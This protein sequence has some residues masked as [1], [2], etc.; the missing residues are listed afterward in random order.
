[1]SLSIIATQKARGVTATGSSESTGEKRK[2]DT[3]GSPAQGQEP[4]GAW[5]DDARVLGKALHD[6]LAAGRSVIPCRADTKKCAL[7]EWTTWQSQIAPWE[8]AKKW[9]GGAI[10]IVGGRVSG[11]LECVDFDDCGSRYAAWSEMVEAEAP[12]LLAKLTIEQ[13][14][15][16]GFHVVYRCTE[17]SIPGSLNLASRG[18]ETE[19]HGYVHVHGKRLKGKRYGA[20]WWAVQ[21]LIETR[22]EG[23]YFVCAPSA[24]YVL[25]QGT[26]KA[27][28]VIT[29]SE[30]KLL[31]GIARRFNEW[32]APE[33]SKDG[34]S[35][36]PNATDRP[37]DDFNSRPDPEP[38]DM[39]IEAD[40]T[41]CGLRGENMEDF[42][43]PGKEEGTSGTLIGGRV[44][45]VHTTNGEPLEGE[46]SYSPFA[47]FTT[48]K[49]GGDF[50]KATKF[51]AENGF[52]KKRG[53]GQADSLSQD[54]HA[55]Q[56]A[57]RYA[58]SFRYDHHVGA[59]FH[60][61]GSRW[62]KQETKLAFQLVREL[63]RELAWGDQDKLTAAHISGV[64][65]LAQADPILACTSEAWDVDPFLLG[66]PGGVVD[67][68][69]GTVMESDPAFMLTKQT[70]VSPADDLDC[71]RWLQFLDEATCGDRQ[72]QRF[73]QQV[74]G[75]ALTG[76]TREHALFF[77]YGP[78]GNGKSVFLNAIT[79]VMGDYATTSSMDTFTESR[80][81]R[82][83]TDLAML[84]GA[85]LVTASE[86]EEGR[87]WAE[88]RIKQLTGGE[89]ISARFMRQDFF[90]FTPQFKL[91]IIGNHQPV[92]NNV[93]DAARRRFNII[94]FV[95]KPANVD[96][97]LEQKLKAEYPG[98]LRWMIQGCVDWL[99]SG[100]VRPDIVSSATQEYFDDQ[101]VFGQWIAEE[102]ERSPSYKEATATLFSAWSR[103][104]ERNGEKPGAIKT[105]SGGLTRR[106]FISG[107]TKSGRHFSGLRL[108]PDQ[109]PF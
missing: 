55:Q 20:K 5:R 87:A 34:R 58:E 102:C 2:N 66:T 15:S 65:K 50:K 17:A 60:W 64:E 75:Y 88:A 68:R 63:C 9:P 109:E 47:L 24:G 23:N 26:H 39:L 83:P 97:Q 29:A 13:S 25:V 12:G 36:N 11:N 27:P 43:R 48:L 72:L 32:A 56:F 54:G 28:P 53:K 90:E 108:K 93:D 3:S 44:F 78:G 22:G 81:E 106:G 95:H 21:K 94:P 80:S 31:L 59:W 6:L 8:T 84:R 67:L 35:W 85:R 69:T 38:R 92:L 45:Y 49:H 52:G 105:F 74:A 91:L 18:H 79:G 41:P 70:T 76:D 104:A 42:T 73:L 19:E 37:G 30:R 1:M 99:Q 98:I 101:D 16:G 14:P 77:V 7:Y 33:W 100:L 40:W 46:R 10:A 62:A 51:L 82:H 71:P 57:D 86:T 4:L 61:N 103:F 89:R 96:K 107:R